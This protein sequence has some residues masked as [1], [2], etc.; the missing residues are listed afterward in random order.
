MRS[1]PRLR[2]IPCVVLAVSGCS[3]RPASPTPAP[4][5]ETVRAVAFVDENR[6][7]A[8]DVSERVRLPGVEVTFGSAT[9]K[10]AVTTGEAQLEVPRGRHAL[11]VR[12]GS[13]PRQFDAP[14]PTEFGPVEPGQ[15]IPV[16]L[17]QKGAGMR[18]D[19]YLAF[20][21]S[22]TYGNPEVGDGHGYR[23]HLEAR[24]RHWFGAARVENEG[25]NSSDS[26]A[27]L[28]RLD[29]ILEHYRPG[30]VLILYGTNDWNHPRCR[31]AE[32][33][34]VENIESMIRV[35]RARGAEPILGTILPTNVGW[36]DRA[37]HGRNDWVAAQNEGIRSLARRE[38]VTLADH[39]AAFEGSS[40]G[41]RRLFIDHVHPSPEGYELMAKTWFE[42]ISSPR[43]PD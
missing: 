5:V 26:Q 22:I 12:P 23:A 41:Y 16:A 37:T 11:L 43:T 21:D 27:G 36:D 1:G 15:T 8:I 2:V 13:V 33:F 38:A 9:A 7:G 25:L 39:H 18:A 17:A 24:L 19:T 31:T 4:P 35:A 40:L 3:G 28:H 42:A 30:F 14:P 34:T 10:T 32:C 20:G 29:A 6:N